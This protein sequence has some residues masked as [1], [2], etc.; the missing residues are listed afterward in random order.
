M[1]RLAHFK[2][3]FAHCE[4]HEDEDP[5]QSG[6]AVTPRQMLELQQQGIPVSSQLAAAV[7]SDGDFRLDF[8]PLL[9]T[10]RHVDICDLW[11]HRMTVRDKFKRGE[12][13]IFSVEPDYAA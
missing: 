11:E 7:F 13:Q 2:P 3:V 9:D 4:L 8:T 12:K 6:L 5:C 1:K 10:Q